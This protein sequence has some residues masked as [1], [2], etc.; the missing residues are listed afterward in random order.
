M[1]S[2]SMRYRTQYFHKIRATKCIRF[3]HQPFGLEKYSFSKRKRNSQFL[4]LGHESI[5]LAL[6]TAV[7]ISCSVSYC[8]FNGSTPKAD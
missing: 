4:I 2:S 5:S 7:N 8:H 1:C 3:L 6:L